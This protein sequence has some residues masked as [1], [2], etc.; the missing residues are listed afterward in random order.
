MDYEKFF[1]IAEDVSC[2]ARQVILRDGYHIQVFLLYCANGAT[3]PVTDADTSV[4]HKQLFDKVKAQNPDRT[5][6][7]CEIWANDIAKDIICEAVRSLASAHDAIGLIHICEAWMRMATT[8]EIKSGDFNPRASQ[9]PDRKEILS[10]AAYTRKNQRC[11]GYIIHRNDDQTIRN[12]EKMPAW[13]KT[14]VTG[15]GRFAECLPA[16]H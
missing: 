16:G 13:G 15:E 8:E 10:V 2:T 1:A 14:E 4:S 5:D 11:Y 6:Q 3:I 12:L 7:E 9:H